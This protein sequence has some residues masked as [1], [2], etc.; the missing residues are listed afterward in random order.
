VLSLSLSLTA[1]YFTAYIQTYIYTVQSSE[2]DNDEVS[3][4][5]PEQMV[6]HGCD[7]RHRPSD[8][9]TR[10]ADRL[11][12]AKQYDQAHQAYLAIIHHPSSPQQSRAHCHW[13]LGEFKAAMLLPTAYDDDNDERFGHVL[14]D[15]DAAIVLG[16]WL[17]LRDCA[18]HIF[19]YGDNWRR[20][21]ASQ[22]LQ[23][24]HNGRVMYGDDDY[25][26]RKERGKAMLRPS[27][28]AGQDWA[29]WML[30]SVCHHANMDTND[31]SVQQREQMEIEVWRDRYAC[32]L[33]GNK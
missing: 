6:F 23:A 21:R 13:M 1:Q 24:P 19:W 29:I 18:E 28:E 9:A 3:A 33:T 26:S 12:D 16:S 32:L 10:S 15:W 11:F 14:D 7:K 27:A 17:A 30:I 4:N 2:A 25:D 8:A 31:P 22:P 5:D 20:R